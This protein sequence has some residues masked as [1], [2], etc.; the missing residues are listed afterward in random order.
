MNNVDKYKEYVDKIYNLNRK[1][2]ST[3]DKYKETVI[4]DVEDELSKYF[5][6]KVID[7]DL[8]NKGEFTENMFLLNDDYGCILE[9]SR[10]S[11]EYYTIFIKSIYKNI[12]FNKFIITNTLYKHSPKNEEN[13][14]DIVK[15][16]YEEMKISNNK[17][18]K[19]K[20]KRAFKKQ[21]D[22]YNL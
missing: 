19:N 18:I 6:K 14:S 22:K 9:I 12:R 4:K 17:K 5:S 11:W 1:T 21:I 3:I 20:K 15:N 8:S 13:I 10:N 7:S 16:L 2:K